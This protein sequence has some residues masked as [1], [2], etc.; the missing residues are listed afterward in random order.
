MRGQ[1]TPSPA[2]RDVNEDLR[3]AMRA[4]N[5]ERARSIL[6]KRDPNLNLELALAN[7]FGDP[8]MMTMLLLNGADPMKPALPFFGR[9]NVGVRDYSEALH[10]DQL[11]TRIFQGAVAPAQPV[12]FRGPDPL[13]ESVELIRALFAIASASCRLASYNPEP[14]GRIRVDV[15][16]ILD[17]WQTW[18]WKPSAYDNAVLAIL[19]VLQA[20]ELENDSGK[21]KNAVY[22]TSLDLRVMAADCKDPLVRGPRV[23]PVDISTYR[24]D[25]SL[26]KGW[27]FSWKKKFFEDAADVPYQPFETLSSPAHANLPPGRYLIVLRKGSRKVGPFDVQF[28]AG[29]ALRELQV[30]DR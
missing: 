3:E 5:L 22:L 7:A 15:E 23:M 1:D 6:K 28:G 2:A 19:H 27:E 11:M 13:H 18:T 16:S 20:A 30:P 17:S 9:F 8:G 14:A 12:D 25:R 24:G 29:E 10:C 21:I 4:G 26:D